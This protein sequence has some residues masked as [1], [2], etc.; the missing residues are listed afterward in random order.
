MSITMEDFK[1]THF[2]FK[3]LSRLPGEPNLATLLTLRAQ[4]KA[5]A[6][7]VHS[8]LG[9]GKHGHLGLVVT[10]T[11]YAAIVGT[12][13]FTRPSLP[14]LTIGESDT[15]YVL[16]EKRHVFMVNMQLF[17]EVNAVERAI[18]QQIVT[19]IDEI[20]LEALYD[21]ITNSISITIPKILS[22]LFDT[23]GM[24][25]PKDLSKMKIKIEGM[26]YDASDP[27]DKV[28]SAIDRFTEVAEICN[29]PHSPEQKGD[30]AYIILQNTKKFSS[31]LAKWDAIQAKAEETATNANTPILPLNWSKFK[32]H[33]REVHK[34]L[35]KRE[36]L[37]VEDAFSR[38]DVANYISEGIREGIELALSAT[39]TP[40]DSS[41]NEETTE[42]DTEQKILMA[43]INELDTTIKSMKEDSVNVAK[44]AHWQQPQIPYWH[45]MMNMPQMMN[46]PF[47]DT[48]TFHHG[49]N[50]NNKNNN[51]YKNK[52]NKY[53]WS[54]GATNHWG[55]QCTKKKQGH[56]DQAHFRNKMG[57][58]V[59]NCRQ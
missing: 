7:S 39:V 25:S 37:T 56:K 43:K 14:T 40:S 44:G 4:I 19:A 33:F 1:N 46:Y 58:N 27:I 30:I 41:S 57:G 48:S 15:Q 5:N 16:A 10:D 29:R 59:K 26:T 31:G 34:G 23:Y 21:P 28:F 17:R 42:S 49:H 54:C 38:D 36:E 6:S 12:V 55:R 45:P 20:Y 8:S 47:P 22:F 11:V 52:N 32:L 51:K 9:G 53:C 13:P 50:N 18:I 2:T 24:V 3:E 35:R